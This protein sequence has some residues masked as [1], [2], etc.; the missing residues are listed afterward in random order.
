VGIYGGQLPFETAAT[1]KQILRTI[2]NLPRHTLTRNLHRSFKVPY[3]YNYITKLCREQAVIIRNHEN[4]NIRTIGKGETRHRKYKETQIWW[5]SGIRSINF[6][7]SG[8]KFEQCINSSTIFCTNLDCR[9][10]DSEEKSYR[11]HIL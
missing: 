11:N 8:Y 6:L 9:S 1:A 5:R 7:D 10:K 4:V 2:G 3:L